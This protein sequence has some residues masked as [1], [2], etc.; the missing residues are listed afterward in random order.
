MEKASDLGRSLHL[1]ETG[2]LVNLQAILAHLA[3][4]PTSCWPAP[5]LIG[6]WWRCGCGQRGR[7]AGFARARWR[8]RCLRHVAAS[9]DRKAGQPTAAELRL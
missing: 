9:L 2:V 5:A 1:T 8:P 3:T 7:P 4:I 6:R